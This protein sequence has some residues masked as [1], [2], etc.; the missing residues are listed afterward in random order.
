MDEKYTVLE[1]KLKKKKLLGYSTLEKFLLLSDLQA[2][3]IKEK[4][5]KKKKRKKKRK[6]DRKKNK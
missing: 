1:I 5:R 6:W 2:Y 4:E 3:T